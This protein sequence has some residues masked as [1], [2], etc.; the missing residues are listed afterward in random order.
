MVRAAWIEMPA[1]RFEAGRLALAHGMDVKG[2]LSRRHTFEKKLKQYSSP[3]LRK[4]Y[5]AHILAFCAL[6]HGL[7]R[8]GGL[9]RNDRRQ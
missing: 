1:S 6:E 9:N 5:R 2:M 3:G 4:R 7:G 8:L